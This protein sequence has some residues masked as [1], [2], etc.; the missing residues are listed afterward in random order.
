[1][2]NGIQLRSWF[3]SG[4]SYFFTAELGIYK[5]FTDALPSYSPLFQTRHEIVYR[6]AVMYVICKT[7]L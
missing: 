6:S 7:K 3:T 1:M 5:L 2:G 4:Q